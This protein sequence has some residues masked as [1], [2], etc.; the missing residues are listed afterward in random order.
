MDE[1]EKDIQI[2]KWTERKVERKDE[3]PALRKKRKI[4]I[5]MQTIIYTKRISF[6]LSP[7]IPLSLSLSFCLSS[8]FSLTQCTPRYWKGEWPIKILMPMTSPYE[9]LRSR[10]SLPAPPN[11]FQLRTLY[12]PHKCCDT[13][14]N[15]AK[16]LL[17]KSSHSTAI[18]AT[19]PSSYFG[20]TRSGFYLNEWGEICYSA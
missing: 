16:V 19:P 13:K 15:S 5:Q 3:W 14:E 18:L 4:C 10:R 17:G 12:S 20:Q 9:S 2:E 11:D 7:L 1:G 6:Q 8:S